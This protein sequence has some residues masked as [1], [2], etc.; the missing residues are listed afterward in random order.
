[1][2][3]KYSIVHAERLGNHQSWADLLGTSVLVIGRSVIAGVRSS[4]ATAT[5]LV[6]ET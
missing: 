4:S 6:T 5:G 2:L 1:M 3:S